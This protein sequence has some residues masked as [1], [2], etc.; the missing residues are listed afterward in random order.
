MS[1]WNVVMTDSVFPSLDGAKSELKAVDAALHLLD[2]DTSLTDPA[3]LDADAVLTVYAQLQKDVVDQLRN[4]KIIARC[5]IGVDNIALDACTER[6]IWVTNVPDYCLD[7]VSDHAL[8]LTL[9]LLRKIPQLNTSLHQGTWVKNSGLT[10]PRLNQVTLG[11]IGFGR[12][13]RSLAAKS[14]AL[15]M[16]IMAYDPGLPEQVIKDGGAVPASFDEVLAASDVISLHCPLMDQTRHL[17][18]AQT[19]A[20]MKKGSFLVNTS[21]GGLIDEAALRAAV[22]SG[23]L[24]GAGIDVFEQEGANFATPLIGLDQVILTPHFAFYS[25]ES[26]MELLRKAAHQ[27]ALVLGGSKPDYPLNNV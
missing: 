3:V 14:Q 1:K 5:G 25:E 24:A 15:G 6:G 10:V 19:L 22:E 20:K 8:G 21:R 13:A 9:A 2:S 11:L 16:R 23:H 12:I 27:I 26:V 4:C 7:E 18:N 17:F